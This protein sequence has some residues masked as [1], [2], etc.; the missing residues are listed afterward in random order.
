MSRPLRIQY[1]GAWYHVMNRG[2]RAETIF[3]DEEDYTMFVAL[4]KESAA[5]WHIHICAYCLMPNHYHL[6]IQ[7][8]EANLSRCM[9]HINGIYTQRYNRR[10]I[11]DGP[12]LRGRYKSILISADNYLLQL[13]RYIH[14]NPVKAKI[15]PTLN[16][17]PWSSHR[18]YLST[19]RKWD[20]IYKEFVYSMLSK[21]RKEWIKRYRAFIRIEEDGAISGVI[22]GKKWPAV[23]GGQDFTDWVKGRYDASQFNRE[24]AQ[25]KALAPES[26]RIIQVVCDF[27]R[28]EQ[29]D[30]YNS[31]RGEFNE[32]RN[33]A[34]FF[35]W[36]VGGE[37]PKKERFQME[38]DS[39]VSSVID[40]LKKR[41]QMDHKLKA[42]VEQLQ[43]MMNKS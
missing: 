14:R 13:V 11:C 30:L 40:R 10:H 12:L 3:S 24:I 36:G 8:P 5:L 35:F 38:K 26:D 34:I 42:R 15:A 21:N 17:Y 31:K 16:D 25:A 27:Y 4:L 39:S 7:T 43:G 37:K 18:G 9:R 20:W 29:N 19:S 23:W 22:E 6:L 32:P 28:V 33:V 41:M 2:R 1:P